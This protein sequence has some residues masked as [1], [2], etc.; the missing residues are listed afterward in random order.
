MKRPQLV[1][2]GTIQRIRQ[3]AEQA[4]YDRDLKHCVELLERGCRLDPADPGL[5]MQ[6]GRMQGVCYDYEAAER[7]FEKAIRVAP[8]KVEAM[9]IAAQQCRDFY[10]TSLAERYLQRAAAEKDASPEIL[11]KLA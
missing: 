8:V 10:N 11:I 6:L 1:S 7:S 4:W 9:A 5:L 3:A 2:K